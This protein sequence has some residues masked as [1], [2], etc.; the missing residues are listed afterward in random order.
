MS[1]TIVA[2]LPPSDPS[3]QPLIK[4]TFPEYRGRKPV[5]LIAATEV[6][7]TNLYWDGGSRSTYAVVTLDGFRPFT[8]PQDNPPQF[9]GSRD[10]PRHA[11]PPGV[12]VIENPT[13]CGKQGALRIS[14]HPDSLAPLLPR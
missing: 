2:K 3:L 11:L 14:V 4:A 1:R 7:F 13:I 10:T 5:T 9:G 12:A 8:L 6:A